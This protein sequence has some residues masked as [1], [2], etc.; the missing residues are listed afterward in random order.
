MSTKV[1]PIEKAIFQNSIVL[2][3]CIITTPQTVANPQSL[4][5]KHTYANGLREITP[6]K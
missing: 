2:K 6:T 5:N 3:L 4:V 1:D